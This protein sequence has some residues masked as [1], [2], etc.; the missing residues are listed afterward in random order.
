MIVAGH[1]T[2]ANMVN[3]LTVSVVDAGRMVGLSRSRIYELLQDGTLE[4][5]K[6]GRRRL[7]VVRSLERLVDQAA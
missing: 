3:Q 4:S 2:E 6:I 1:S 7:I 5:R